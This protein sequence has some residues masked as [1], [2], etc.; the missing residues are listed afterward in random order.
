MADPDFTDPCVTANWLR[1]IYY[2]RIAGEAVSELRFGERS[3]KYA[4]MDEAKMRAAI[5]QLDEECAIKTGKPPRRH[6]IRL[7]ARTTNALAP[8]F[9]VDP[10]EE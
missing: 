1:S 4:T 2:A 10:A 3:I 6:A 7:G 5:Q 9:Q 8:F